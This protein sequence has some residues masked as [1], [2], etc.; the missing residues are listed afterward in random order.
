MVVKEPWM[1]TMTSNEKT[2]NAW[3]TYQAI[4][5]HFTREYDYFKYN[6][7]L[8][9]TYDSMERHFNKYERNSN[10]SAQR[11]IFDNLGKS[12]EHKEDLIFFY[13]SQFTNDITYPS[14][15]DSDLYDEYKERMNN[16]HFHLKRDI[17]EII[18]YMDEYCKT[19]DDLFVAEKVNH[20]PI[21]KLGLSRSISVETFTT[22]D[23][24]LNF[25]PQMEKKL[26]DPASKDF[27][28]LV[29][30]YKPFLSINVE[31]EK[32]IIMDVLTK[33]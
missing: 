5:A 26:I 11:T 4:N 24:I 12:F 20:P 23:I 17:E 10:F 7:K 19:F 13:L 27:I 16:F 29:R 8:N 31:K 3:I 21:L 18:K 2:F 30:N 1:T 14:I 25:L 22:L 28:K 32:K 9:M 33:G 15:F 6:G